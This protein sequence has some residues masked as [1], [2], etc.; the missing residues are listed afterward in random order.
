VSRA[1]EVL[2]EMRR[3]LAGMDE[4]KPGRLTA[5]GRTALEAAT[6]RWRGKKPLPPGHRYVSVDKPHLD[7]EEDDCWT[8]ERCAGWG[9]TYVRLGRQMDY[10]VVGVV[11]PADKG[12]C[13]GYGIVHGISDAGRGRP[14]VVERVEAPS[15]GSQRSA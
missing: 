6:D 9:E 14:V 1:T 4:R 8:C 10:E 11:C 15:R 12:G 2:D 5:D 3:T 13:D 7:L